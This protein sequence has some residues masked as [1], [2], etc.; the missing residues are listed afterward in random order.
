MLNYRSAFSSP[1]PNN[2]PSLEP[3]PKESLEALGKHGEE[4]A[5]FGFPLERMVPLERIQRQQSSSS[6]SADESDEQEEDRLPWPLS[7]P[8][9]SSLLSRR[10]NFETVVD[11]YIEHYEHSPPYTMVFVEN[12]M[13]EPHSPTASMMIMHAPADSNELHLLKA[14]DSDPLRDDPWNPA[15]RILHHSTRGDKTVVCFERLFE[16]DQPPLATVA[17]VV[18]F[19][20]QALEGLSFL[21][22]NRIAHRAYGEAGAVMVDIGMSDPTKFDRAHLPVRYYRV[23][24]SQAEQLDANASLRCAAFVQ[25]VRDCGRMFTALAD[26]VPPIGRKLKTLINAMDGGEYGA[27]DARKLFEALCRTIDHDTY[28][29]L[30]SALS[31]TTS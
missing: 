1:S 10:A 21:H 25:D 20:R 29:T 2:T 16:Y 19:V 22:E 28:E 14:L 3:S 4:D 30:L 31:P 18:D 15:P 12:L 6:E 11:E 5:G 8:S 17:N 7:M 26:E 23:D 24:F 13:D 27:E 9:S